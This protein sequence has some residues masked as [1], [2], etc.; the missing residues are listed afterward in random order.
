MENG[1]DQNFPEGEPP[2]MLPEFPPWGWSHAH[3]VAS[4]HPPRANVLGGM[5]RYGPHSEAP[6]CRK[7]CWGEGRQEECGEGSAQPAEVQEASQ[8]GESKIRPEDKEE[9][10]Q[11]TRQKQEAAQ[12]RLPLSLRIVLLLSASSYSLKSGGQGGEE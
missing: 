9:L 8:S 5:L 12:G 3:Q 2:N 6:C 4:P 7:P 10:L 11:A 1:K